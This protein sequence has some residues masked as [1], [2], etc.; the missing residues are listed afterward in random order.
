MF[1]WFKNL[2][3]RLR[4]FVA[5]GFAALL[6]VI[7]ALG[8]IAIIDILNKGMLTTSQDVQ[9]NID[10]SVANL[11]IHQ[12]VTDLTSS[13]LGAESPSEL[14]R[15]NV[16][17]VL[18][19][20]KKE[21]SDATFDWSIEKVLHD[22]YETKAS[23]LASSED[24]NS[25]LV[26]F[27]SEAEA[28]SSEMSSSLEELAL[29]NS[30]K[31]EQ[32]QT[33]IS[34]ETTEGVNS[35]LEELSGTMTTTLDDVVLVLQM[36][37]KVLEL[38]LAVRGYINKPDAQA[39]ASIKSIM[40]DLQ[41]KLDNIPENVAGPFEVMEFTS[42][43]DQAT[44]ILEGDSG[45]LVT[46]TATIQAREELETVLKDLDERLS[47]LADNTV[48]DGSA[49]LKDYLSTVKESL[50][51]SLDV[52]IDNQK[53]VTKS[54][55]ESTELER[56]GAK[57][58]QDLFQIAFRIQSVA[59]ARN[60][61]QL[62]ELE[63]E[64][65]ELLSA[66]T[67]LKAEALSKLN[68]M[69]AGD[70][71][72][73][74]G[75]NIDNVL[76][77]IEGD[78][79]VLAV[80]R[81]LVG[82]YAET[83][84]ANHKIED[85][86]NKTSKEMINSF[87]AL[88]QNTQTRMADDVESSKG[89]LFGFMIVG[90]VIVAITLILGYFIGTGISKMLTGVVYKLFN[91]SDRLS[92]SAASMAQQSE[93]QASMS[94]EQAAALEESSS[95]IEEISS[96]AAKNADAS[97]EAATISSEVQNATING[98]QKMAEMNHAMDEI[99]KASEQIGNIIRTIDEIAFQTNIL[100]L[101]AAVE[102]ARAGEAGA[103]FA[104]VADEV[105]NLALKSKNAAQETEEIIARNG[106]RT[107]EGVNLCGDVGHA[108]DSINEKIGSLNALIASIAE[109]TQEQ[110]TGLEQI[111]RGIAET[112][113]S[114]QK[115]A[116]LAEQGASSSQELSQE[117]KNLIEMLQTLSRLSGASSD[118]SERSSASAMIDEPAQYDR[119]DSGYNEQSETYGGGFVS[120][121]SDDQEPEMSGRF[122]S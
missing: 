116:A 28:L 11:A 42:L 105:R 27:L 74:L 97:R 65:G 112:S 37:G 67:S 98:T 46:K 40:E 78:D 68:A 104:V 102:A 99:N 85:S 55:S 103:G 90:I 59:L 25:R 61:E 60:S 93:E 87:I 79:G 76:A 31:A 100:A 53:N 34:T 19:S 50:G 17:S 33:Q 44:E 75:A 29:K 21:Y 120:E 107:K 95:T 38:D 82:R 114:T 73:D 35:N 56:I 115:N 10:T 111:N 8:S 16:D 51:S 58:N 5:I 88:S 110:S 23:Y 52:L 18:R 26:V 92:H 41:D 101:N 96:M 70:I 36:R 118:D 113:T 69:N 9:A 47:E 63:S 71:A 72:D 117:S 86:L 6:T 24:L 30:K 80:T 81:Q 7:M 106:A 66:I 48:F 45:I 122:L 119:L 15:T 2:N 89:Y 1:N 54:F 91:L 32:E 84:E 14:S 43:N 94:S 20:L 77:K 3:I 49:A 62:S 57:I 39:E 83:I 64:S 13:I 109:A 108:L 121:S 12:E 4:I 22:F